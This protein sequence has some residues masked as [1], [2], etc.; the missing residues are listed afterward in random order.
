MTRSE[1]AK[2]N[3]KLKKQ[4]ARATLLGFIK[5]SLL[6]DE[7]KKTDGT[8]NIKELSKATGLH[9]NTIRNHLKE[10]REEGIIWKKK[11]WKNLER[12]L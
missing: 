8:W 10:M 11:H 9:R 12:D 1:R 6:A 4:R 7:Y 2:E 3:A 5:D